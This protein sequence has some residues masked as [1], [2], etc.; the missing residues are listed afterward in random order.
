MNNSDETPAV[1]PS[2]P[3]PDQDWNLKSC[4]APDFVSRWLS[5]RLPP[6]HEDL[7]TPDVARLTRRLRR[8]LAGLCLVRRFSKHFQRRGHARVARRSDGIARIAR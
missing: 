3:I 7:C 1:Q 6:L 8:A 5:E 4:K 2:T